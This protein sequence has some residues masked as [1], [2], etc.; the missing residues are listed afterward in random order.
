MSIATSFALNPQA[1]TLVHPTT[2]LAKENDKIEKSA[3]DFES[4]LLTGWLQQ[5]EQSFA[6]LPGATD[7]DADPGSDQLQGIAMQSLGSSLTASGG[8]GLAKVI[9]QQLHKAADTAASTATKLT[10]M[11]IATNFL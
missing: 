2:S 8:I 4:L 10:P 5:A 1:N 11:T 6:K 7:E 9:A 3:K